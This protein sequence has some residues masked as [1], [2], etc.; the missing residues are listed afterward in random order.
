[1]AADTTG[2][3]VHLKNENVDKYPEHSYFVNAGLNTHRATRNDIKPNNNTFRPEGPDI[4]GLAMTSTN[5]FV[6]A[7]GQIV[8]MIQSF[9]VSESRSVDQLQA[10]G[11]E[12]VIQA[13]PNNTNGGTLS[14]NRIALYSSNLWNALGMS[15]SG[16]G[17]DKSGAIV[18]N[19]ASVADSTP[20]A[21]SVGAAEQDNW[22]TSNVYANTAENRTLSN[23]ARYVF[24][25]LKDQRV[26]LEI[27]VRTP[28][29][30]QGV[31]GAGTNNSNN[32]QLYYTETY[33]DCWLSSYSKSYD[34]GRITVAESCNIDYA[35]VY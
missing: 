30:G 6:Y 28:L 22:D 1:M 12:G 35:D 29:T 10:L 5:V 32:T 27:Q 23:N 17:Y 26:P 15:T 18:Y 20:R 16:H 33:V 19:S 4:N 2:T 13:V 3:K 9:S 21:A 31:F 25:T 34:V 8:G 11:T 7:N 14:V 24:K